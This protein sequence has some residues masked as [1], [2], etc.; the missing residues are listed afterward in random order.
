MTAPHDTTTAKYWKS[1][2]ARAGL[3]E[4]PPLPGVNR[5]GFLEAAGFATS[6][7]ALGGCQRAPTT[8]VP[9]LTNDTDNVRPGRARSFATT[10]GGCAAGCGMLAT[11]RDG[12]PLKMEGMPEHPLSRGGLCAVGQAQ[13]MELYDQ[14][15]LRGP[16]AA[17]KAAT[18]SEVDAR[19]AAALA[20][21]PASGAVRV[22]TTSTSS[23]TL[24]RAIAAFLKR[25]PDGRHVEAD[26][27]SVSAILDAHAATH[28]AR[29]L[30][31]YRFDKANV[32]VSFG[33][34]F[35][36]TW[37]SPVEFA[38]AWKSGRALPHREVVH[39]HGAEA[40]GAADASNAHAP[41]K[42]GRTDAAMS[43]HVQFESR[44]TLTGSN[45]D[46]RHRLHP[47]E[48]GLVL[49]HLLHRVARLA[50]ESG[51]P[52]PLASPS[53]SA[54]VLDALASRLWE[55]RGK[56][57]VV[58]GA[59][60]V[61]TQT[62]VNHL[63]Q[64]LDAYGNTLDVDRP[65]Q[66]LRGDDRETEALAE[67]L[68]S[69]KV[70]ALFVADIDLVHDFPGGEAIAKDLSRVPLVVSLAT[71][72]DDTSAASRF[73]CPD[74]HPLASWGDAEPIAGLFSLR[75]PMMQPL[76]NARS[77]I[78]SFAAW[79]GSGGTVLSL[80]R[81]TW[82]EVA[83]PRQA[84]ETDF[85]R[86][87]DRAVHDGFV[88]VDADIEKLAYRGFDPQYVA[89]AA[90]GKG[91]AVVLH[92]QIA[93]PSSRHAHNPWLQELPDPITKITWD[94]C[95][96]LSPRLARELGVADN[97]V[98]SL[99][100][101][102]GVVLELPA[103]IQPGQHD[104]VAAIA[105]GYG[106]RGTDRFARVG[107]QWLEG[108]STVGVNGLV[109]VNAAPLLRFGGGVVQYVRDNVQIAKTGRRHTLATTQ[110]HDHIE[111]PANVAPPGSKPRDI[112]QET[113][114][115][116]YHQNPAAGAPHAHHAA[117]GELWPDDHPYNGHRWGMAIDLNAC[118]GCSACLIAC[119]AENNVPVVG[120]DEVARH[121]EMHWIRID[122]YYT[123]DDD[124]PA[125]VHQPMMCQHCANAPCETVCPVL[126]TVHSSEGLNQQVYNRCVGTRYCA[127]NCPYKVR[128]FNWFDYVHDDALANLAL[129]PDVTV[130][131]RGIMEKCS[132][133]VKRI[134]EGKIEA[135]RLGIPLADGAIRTA[136]Q[137]S[138]PTNAIVFGDVNDADS[139]IARAMSDARRY[140]VLEE[141]NVRPSIGYLRKVR[142]AT[143]EEGDV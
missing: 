130:R 75:Q 1:P 7:V 14:E 41:A 24:R 119:Q 143:R 4:E 115:D 47:G 31:R 95:V 90:T 46:V 17:G 113:T 3:R 89:A 67:E 134:Q 77:A 20:K 44:M 78:E 48:M 38:A 116:E 121:R 131:M 114:L 34:D 101:G 58:C 73:V 8:I 137:Q 10:C 53:I 105:L 125:V 69:G 23:P 28:G 49:S 52:T 68:A 36:G 76:G 110:L 70:A 100:I 104:D 108:R 51:S 141:L 84:K 72:M 40:G 9:A 27:V 16:L 81:A 5:R 79:S 107:P 122:R 42:T 25:F 129:N 133:C 39:E 64:L 123:G 80:V 22:V 86:F 91:V 118:S 59:N 37:I 56:A 32:I 63:S 66:Q 124:D 94:N 106:V 19:I 97:D 50:G 139:A 60:D 82:K 13:V 117:E 65:S 127:N 18:W 55:N 120:R 93:I 11:V 85:T 98:V 45:A 99:K 96:T 35:L 71:R 126:A 83:F 128:R 142:N 21:I 2:A 92:P 29:R 33:A 132:L 88:E 138:C 12:R 15:R 103:F 136:C 26:S 54:A 74:E 112:V 102:D 135:R 87:W 30:P 6:L 109:G 61:P 57:L 43:H 140:S 111:V 62:L